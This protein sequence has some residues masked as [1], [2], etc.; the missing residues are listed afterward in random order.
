MNARTIAWII[1]AILVVGALL[2][3]WNTPVSNGGL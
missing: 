1:V 2:W 3:A